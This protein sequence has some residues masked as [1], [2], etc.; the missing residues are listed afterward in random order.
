MIVY[1]RFDDVTFIY[2]SAE[3]PDAIEAVNFDFRLSENFVE[4]NL[5]KKR[6]FV[7][8][9]QP[10]TRVDRDVTSRVR[11]H[12]DSLLIFLKLVFNLI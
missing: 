12:L 1:T 8:L 3:S 5:R 7:D 11:R 4:S 6:E 10:A 9:Q 2:R